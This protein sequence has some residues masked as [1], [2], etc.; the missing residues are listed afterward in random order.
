M[1]LKLALLILAIAA[2]V[3]FANALD[4]NTIDLTLKGSWQWGVTDHTPY[5]LIASGSGHVIDHAFSINADSEQENKISFNHLGVANYTIITRMSIGNPGRYWRGFYVEKNGQACKAND[6]RGFFETELFVL[7]SKAINEFSNCG[8]VFEAE[9]EELTIETDT[10]LHNVGLTEKEYTANVNNYAKKITS[11]AKITA[12][13]LQT[14]DT[15]LR[16]IDTK[17]DFYNNGAFLVYSKGPL[18]MSEGDGWD[19]TRNRAVI[20]TDNLKPLYIISLRQSLK[21]YTGANDLIVRKVKPEFKD[22]KI[23]EIAKERVGEQK[24]LAIMTWDGWADTPLQ[25]Q[26]V[27]SELYERLAATGYSTVE[28]G[29]LAG[30]STVA[31][32]AVYDVT[33]VAGSTVT[34]SLGYL[35][36]TSGF[37]SS[38]TL[39]AIAF[40]PGW[41]IVGGAAVGMAI[42]GTTYAFTETDVYAYDGLNL[43]FNWDWELWGRNEAKINF[44]LVK[45]PDF[46]PTDGGTPETLGEGKVKITFT[47]LDKLKEKTKKYNNGQG[48]GFEEIFSTVYIT[49]DS[50]KKLEGITSSK[51]KEGENAIVFSGFEKGKKYQV[52]V[53]FEGYKPLKYEE[54]P[55][56]DSAFK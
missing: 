54:F 4:P 32:L 10:Q 5:Q 43:Q 19:K 39:G 51:Q 13:Q 27:D 55:V 46:V 31:G 48:Y 12:S 2:L 21:P 7:S 26:K 29:A 37:G 30:V 16:A 50:G 6:G 40:P 1:K 42:A 44:I 24:W 11:E 45:N 25:Y 23:T 34:G 41:I 22:K 28:G 36:S 35:F 15:D 52:W 53:D 49:D 20:I 17:T 8:V 18:G 33:S 14:L 9:A 38:A 47:D 3:S 56:E